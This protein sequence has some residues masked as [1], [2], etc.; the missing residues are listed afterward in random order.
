L[1][2]LEH[3]ECCGYKFSKLCIALHIFVFWWLYLKCQIMFFLDLIAIVMFITCIPY[4]LSFIVHS[5]PIFSSNLKFQ[6]TISI[7][8]FIRLNQ[9]I[10]HMCIPHT[11]SFST[12]C[13]SSHMLTFICNMSQF[14]FH[15]SSLISHGHCSSTTWHHSFAI[16]SIL[17]VFSFM[18]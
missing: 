5:F 11:C 18:H 7:E 8:Y 1:K 6:D 15:M 3:S 12:C 10:V 17:C 14:I 9:N 4:S 16:T 2:L 13:F